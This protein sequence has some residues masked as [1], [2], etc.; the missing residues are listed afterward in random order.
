VMDGYEAARRIRTDPA[1]RHLPVIAMTA[2]AMAGDRERAL[3]AG[4]D[5]YIAKPLD[6][7]SMFRTIAR[8]VGARC[9]VSGSAAAAV[10]APAPAPPP[11]GPSLPH[12]PGIDTRAGLAT[13]MHNE[14]LYRS[15]LG[16]FHAAQ[17]AFVS[18]FRAAQGADDASAPERLAHTLKS[19]AGSIG[20]RGVQSAAAALEGAC[21]KGESA[22]CIDALLDKVALELA[23]VLEGLAALLTP[24]VAAATPAA[25]PADPAQL[26]ALLKELEALLIAGDSGSQDWVAAHSGHLQAAC[27]QA[28][29]AIADA[30]ENFDF[31]AALSLLQ[32]ACLTP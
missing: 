3:A 28:H 29:Q 15:L 12:L 13:T 26:R 1:L 14:V 19:V 18:T 10:Q 27:P 2:N 24:P 21:R 11:A 31:E 4:M 30:V 9:A 5:D 25:Q 6:V 8:W 22:P 20:A 23:P 17:S 7:G 16:K 32:E